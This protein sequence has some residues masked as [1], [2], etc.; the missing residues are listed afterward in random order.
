MERKGWSSHFS[1]L[2]PDL[3]QVSVKA[4]IKHRDDGKGWEMRVAG[5]GGEV[6]WC[7]KKA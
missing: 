7:L 2:K 3:M 6:G 1:R 4:L 5:G